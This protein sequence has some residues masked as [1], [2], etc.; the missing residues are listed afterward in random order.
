[1]GGLGRGNNRNGR[2][3]GRGR[4]GRGR[5]GFRGGRGRGVGKRQHRGGYGGGMGLY[6][7]G[8]RQMVGQYGG[9]G[10]TSMYTTSFAE[11]LQVMYQMV[12]KHGLHPT[13]AV[14]QKSQNGGR[15]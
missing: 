3:R 4:G 1:M 11:P 8:F 10:G 2:G 14:L 6:T 13:I 15:A 5:R 7:P 12:Q 9:H